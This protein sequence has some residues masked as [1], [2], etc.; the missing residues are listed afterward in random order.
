MTNFLKRGLL[1]IERNP[2]ILS[3]LALIVIIPLFI[4]LSTSF[5]TKNFQQ[6]IDDTLRRKALM[7]ESIFSSYAA[8]YYKE[9]EVLENKITK[10][11]GDNPEIENFKVYLPSSNDKFKIIASQN[12]SEQAK[13][14]SL[15]S[16]L[17]SWHKDQAI[18][19]LSSEHGIRF[20]N[21]VNPFYDSQ[22]KKIGLISIAMSLQD[23]D[24]IV[25]KN[26][27]NAYIFLLISILII[28][29][30]VVQHTRLFQYVALLRKTRELDKAKDSFMN[31]AVHEL[32]SPLVNILDYI[33][34]LRK[35]LTGKLSPEEE[36]DL[37]RVSISAKRLNDLV[38][39]I[40]NV[41]RIQ[42]GRLS[43]VP[44]KILPV[45]IA[46]EVMEELRVKAQKAGLKLEIVAQRGS[47]LPVYVNP[48]R[49]KEVL[50]NLIDNAIKYTKK[51][52]I[53][54]VVEG[55][56]IRKK[57]YIS[58]EDTG[59]GISAE[60]RSHIFEKFFRVKSRET[61][62][63]SGT[64][65]GLWIVKQIIQKMKGEILVESIKGVG[66]KFI[67]ILPLAKT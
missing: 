11:V 20:W 42:Q 14:V 13:E 41:V 16:L 47:D 55:N 15:T 29:V 53:K 51:G 52:G 61:A 60:D 30:L 12:K 7:A 10:I 2:A 40:L 37:A 43:F 6:T 45:E 33:Y 19:Y 9:P 54:V 57:A 36:E 48:D 49:L 35:E 31:M 66:T 22:K 24:N 67:V 26:I 58:V 65:L 18:A 25:Y 34:E 62:D 56:I 64:G 27:R 17:L 50:F 23:V 1:F 4:F 59:I 46:R 21:V 8:Q 3:S 32:R 38:S 39:D 28:L 5:L 63:V 44:K